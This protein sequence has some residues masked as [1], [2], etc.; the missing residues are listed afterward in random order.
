MA[1]NEMTPTNRLRFVQR[2]DLAPHLPHCLLH[3]ESTGCTCGGSITYRNVLQ[4][5]WEEEYTPDQANRDITLMLMGGSESE[6]SKRRGEWR[7]VP[8]GVET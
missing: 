4:Q 6:F 8:V 2:V 1:N 7:D 3:K 5:Y